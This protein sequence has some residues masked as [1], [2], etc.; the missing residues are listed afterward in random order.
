MGKKQAYLSCLTNRIAPQLIAL[1]SCSNPQKNQ[2]VCNE[3]Q[4][5]GFWFPFFC[6]WCHKWVRFLAILAHVT[7]SRAQPLDRSF[8]LKFSLDTRLESESLEPLI[9]FLGFWV[10][11]VGSKINK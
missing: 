2:Q 3:K 6:E 4:I 5:L 9:I 11:K 8:A 7:W 1:K 10:Q